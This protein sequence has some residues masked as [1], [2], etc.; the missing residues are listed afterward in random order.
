MQEQSEGLV[1]LL[2]GMPIFEAEWVLWFLIALSALSAAVM[3]ERG[4]FYA[5]HRVNVDDVRE[6]L[7][8]FLDAGD[9]AGAVAWLQGIDSLQTNVVA[10][11]LRDSALGPDSVEDLVAGA[12]TA[13][14]SRY[15]KRLT[16]LATIGSNAPF[17]GLFGTV[18]GIIRAFH[19]L[20]VDSS[21][22]S[23]AVMAGVSEALVAT[24][25]GLVVAIPA[26]VAYNTFKAQVKGAVSDT[27]LLSR[28]MLAF[29]KGDRRPAE[30]G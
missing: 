4:W 14:R 3:L 7:V 5:R 20:S 12:I 24:A 21:D 25:V 30:E 23:A 10:Y 6:R 29:L 22:A 1:Q 17:I 9:L 28:T 11:G 15:E 2:M 8:G 26:V 27:Q 13:E 19:D 16:V 18:L